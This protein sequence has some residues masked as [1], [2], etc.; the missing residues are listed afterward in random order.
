MKE[1]NKTPEKQLSNKEGEPTYQMQS[2]TTGNQDAHRN[3]WVL[4]QSRGKSEGYGK[5]REEK[6]TGSQQWEEG[7]QDSNQWFGPEGRNKHS[8]RIEWRTRIQRN[9]ERLRNFW[10]NFKC[11]NIQTIGVPKWEEEEQEI[12]NLLEK[13]RNTSQSGEGNGLPGSPG[14]SQ[15]PKEI[16]SKQ[17]HTK[18]HH[19]HILQ[20]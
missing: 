9:E 3:G 5:W 14:I 6:Y 15:S 7:K 12:E 1:R 19:N 16:G 18:T 11:S 2:Q 17:E 4:L 8:T 10:D 13:I 20:N